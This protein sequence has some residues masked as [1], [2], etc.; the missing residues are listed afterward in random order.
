MLEVEALR[1]MLLGLLVLPALAAVV[2]ALLGPGRG[3]AIRWISLAA[4]LA[5]LVLAVVVAAGFAALHAEH[6]AA[7][8]RAKENSS[9]GKPAVP[10]FKPEIVPGATAKDRHRTDW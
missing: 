5:E 6:A 9:A 1:L 4:V 7:L 8:D 10:T 3:S 2:V